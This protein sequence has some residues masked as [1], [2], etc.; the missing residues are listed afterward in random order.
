MHTAFLR[1]G[2]LVCPALYQMSAP[3]SPTVLPAQLWGKGT[4]SPGTPGFGKGP[5]VY[6][7]FPGLP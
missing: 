4:Q 2:H 5:P 7:S 1:A 3:L 6:T